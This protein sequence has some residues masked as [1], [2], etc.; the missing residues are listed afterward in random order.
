M[1]RPKRATKKESADA[2]TAFRKLTKADALLFYVIEIL[3]GMR[4]K[5]VATPIEAAREEIARR[6]EASQEVAYMQMKAGRARTPSTSG[7]A[8]RKP[9]RSRSAR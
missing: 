7:P 1:N 3:K 2:L 5:E 9:R 8:I 6:M 4:L